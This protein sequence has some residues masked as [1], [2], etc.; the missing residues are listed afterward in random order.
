MP[1]VVEY[2]LCLIEQTIIFT[3]FSSL[4]EKRFKNIVPIILIIFTNSFLIFLCTD[5]MLYLRV[6]IFTTITILGSL[7]LFKAKAYIKISFSVML[8]FLFSIID[9]VFGLLFSLIMDKQFFDVL[10]E[11]LIRR[12]ILCFFIKAVNAIVILVVYKLFL[13]THF[14]GSRKTWVLFCLVMTTFLF[15][16]VAFFEIYQNSPGTPET[17]TLLFAVSTAFFITGMIIIFFF[18]H[19][20]KS[21]FNEKKMYVLEANYEGVREQLAVQSDNSEKL[22]KIRHD[23]KNHLL[24]A[25]QLISQNQYDA[26]ETLVDEMIGQTNSI[27]LQSKAA[28]GNDIIDATLSLKG[29]ICKSR[30]IQFDLTYEHL[31]QLKISEVDLSSLCSN[32]LDNAI[33]AAEKANAPYISL[34]LFIRGDYLNI[35]SEN[36]YTG[37]IKKSEK[38]KNAILSTTKSNPAEHGFGTKIISEIAEKY[39]GVCVYEH[40]GGIFKMNVMLKIN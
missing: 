15:V 24:N 1:K 26:A 22:G 6:I 5:I 7:I 33:S 2:I 31:P 35:V 3:F 39:D 25:K 23:I 18:T 10:S 37:E 36:S 4:L 12:I 11:N 34:S 19:I 28:T 21:L 38:D 16:A 27:K 20:C 40:G 9:I 29:A 17:A 13:K 14:E 32:I 8:L 30:N